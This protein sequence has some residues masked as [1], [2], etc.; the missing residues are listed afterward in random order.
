LIYL[1][2]DTFMLKMKIRNPIALRGNMSKA[3]N[4]VKKILGVCL[5]ERWVG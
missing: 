4:F 1:T 3:R 2:G 5:G